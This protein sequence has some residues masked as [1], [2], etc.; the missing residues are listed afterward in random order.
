[1][2][3]N[4]CYNNEI[5]SQNISWSFFNSS[6]PD[7]YGLSC[8]LVMEELT[9]YQVD[10]C[11]DGSVELYSWGWEPFS[12][13]DFLEVCCEQGSGCDQTSSETSSQ[14][15]GNPTSLLDAAGSTL[16]GMATAAMVMFLFTQ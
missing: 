11:V 12:G 14:T 7:E 6:W 15:G 1:M 3:D 16:P 10:V 2:T 9:Y 4:Q 8:E 5:S 13:R